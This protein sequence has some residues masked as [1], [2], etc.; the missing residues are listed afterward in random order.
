MECQIN[1]GAIICIR[2][3]LYVCC[4]NRKL[5]TVF[6]EEYKRELKKL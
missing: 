2:H 4:H 6:V 3:K 1:V 5:S